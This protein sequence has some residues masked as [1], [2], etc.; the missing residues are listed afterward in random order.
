MIL[1]DYAYAK[2]NLSLDVIS[3]RADGYH[4]LK[5]VVQSVN[6]RDEVTVECVPGEGV[7]IADPGFSFLP[8]DERNI[9][10]KAANAFFG[11]A[12]ISGW[13]AIIRIKKNIPVG[14]GLGGGSADGACV[15]RM[16]D[17]M[18]GTKYSRED[19]VGL[20]IAVGSDVPVCILGG[21]KL[22]EGRGE[23]LTDIS[24]LP[25][26]HVVI[27]KPWFTCST[28]ELY[29]RIDCKNI[30]IRP[31]TDGLIRA[32]G[33][34]DLADASRYLYNVF[35]DV[36]PRGKRDIEDIKYA[37]LDSG[38]LGA[39]MSG[40]GPSVFGLFN[41]EANARLAYENLV[42]LYKDCFITQTAC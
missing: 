22:V 29:K 9:A 10:A 34:G 2:I 19:F 33:K 42:P 37:M 25:H 6:L 21:T 26:C 16:L 23:V 13:Q 31:D 18:F 12:G 11:Y 41:N 17:R 30:R 38:A 3:K 35:E 8:D 7:R 28:P 40:S 32:I 5:M 15:L 27:C 36:L 20:G 24:P 14:A 4:D 1:T 39:A